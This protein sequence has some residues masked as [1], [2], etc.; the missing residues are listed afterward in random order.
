MCASESEASNATALIDWSALL[1]R[2]GG[3]QAF[4]A[5]LANTALQSQAETPAKLRA[6]V[7]QSDLETIAFVAHAIKGMAGNLMAAALREQAAETESAARA[8]DANARVLGRE[9]GARLEAFL[10]E[11]AARV[12]S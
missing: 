12:A 8:G 4:V 3:R 1:A 11:L 10:A 7:E 9:L 6:A 5:K 2:Y